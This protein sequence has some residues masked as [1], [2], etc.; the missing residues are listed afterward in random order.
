MK[1]VFM[2]IA[3]WSLNFVP[4]SM[5]M[6]CR[7]VPA[8]YQRQRGGPRFLRSPENQPAEDPAR[9]DSLARSPDG[10]WESQNRMLA[11]QQIGRPQFPVFSRFG[12]KRA[13]CWISAVPDSISAVQPQRSPGLVELFERVRGLHRCLTGAASI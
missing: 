7:L 2:I 3:P 13:F 10:R 6:E 9:G 11:A 5:R 8:G 1:N 12:S 4:I